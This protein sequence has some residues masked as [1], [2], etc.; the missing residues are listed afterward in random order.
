MFVFEFGADVYERAALH[1]FSRIFRS[2]VGLA[3]LNTSKSAYCGL[4]K[5]VL[6]PDDP[7]ASHLIC[8][9]VDDTQ[10]GSLGTLTCHEGRRTR[11]V[12]HSS[13]AIHAE[14]LGHG[15]ASPLGSAPSTVL[16]FGAGSAFGVFAAP[17]SLCGIYR[18]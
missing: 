13:S 5:H 14:D 4:L 8:I 2:L 17:R 3:Y 15:H 11:K 9:G 16:V 18:R 6:L 1:V 12:K 7:C 10:Q